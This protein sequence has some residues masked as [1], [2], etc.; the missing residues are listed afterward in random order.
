MVD[1]TPSDYHLTYLRER[2]ERDRSSRIFLQLAEEYR[3]RGLRT[4]ALEVLQAGLGFHPGYL[5]AQV[6]LGRCLLEA[7]QASVALPVLER[8]LKQDP[9]QAV[10]TRLL[11]ETWL[12]LGDEDSAQAAIDR[13]RLIGVPP[14]E[15]TSL[16]ERLKELRAPRPG[17]WPEQ[18]ELEAT[19]P[20][21]GRPRPT[22]PEA[23]VPA[24]PPIPAP[25]IPP[26]AGPE[27]EPLPPQAAEPPPAPA[28]R[29]AAATAA[30]PSLAAAEA[31]AVPAETAEPAAGEPAAAEPA[32]GEVFHLPPG[33]PRSVVLPLRPGDGDRRLSGGRAGEPFAAVAR[34]RVRPTPAGEIFR[35]LPAPAAVSAPADAPSLP[36]PPAPRPP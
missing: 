22:P 23:A 16:T 8:V 33:R 1:P 5:A 10:A 14:S 11:A 19:M 24:A 13:C 29:S 2:W 7:G 31:T 21:T 17:A 9:T 3:R 35:L 32:A 18:P 12:Q 25:A 30:A 4:E 36:P 6:A 20:G 26:P 34:P 27:P 15:L 28:A